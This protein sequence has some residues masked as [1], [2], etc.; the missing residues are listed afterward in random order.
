MSITIGLIYNNLVSQ[1]V[2]S[3]IGIGFFFIGV[4]ME[5]ILETFWLGDEYTF[6]VSSWIVFTWLVYEIHLAARVMTNQS[7]GNK[8]SIILL[9]YSIAYN[10][11][12]RL[13]HL[14]FVYKRSPSP[15][16]DDTRRVYSL[17]VPP[18]NF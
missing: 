12:A 7:F 3:F 2:A 8:I 11:G 16:R 9:Q 4:I 14:Y 5:Y 1:A 15:R 18:R 17:I 6:T 10:T 13:F